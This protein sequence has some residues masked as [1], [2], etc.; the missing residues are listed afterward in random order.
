[1]GSILRITANTIMPAP[2]QRVLKEAD[3]MVLGQAQS[4]LDLAQDQ[5][6]QILHD[7]KAT[8]E[9]QREQGYL[10]GKTEGKMEHAEK[11]MDTV[12]SSVEFIENIE[13]TLVHVVSQAIRKEIGRASCRERV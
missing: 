2:G 8:Y 6:N 11:I 1:M 10:D 5:A 13:T 9:E 3:L 7:A 4:I 12:L